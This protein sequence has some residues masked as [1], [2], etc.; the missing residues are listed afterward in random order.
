MHPEQ[1]SRIAYEGEQVIAFPKK[2]L[3]KC[4]RL[5]LIKHL[6]INRIGIFP[7]AANHYYSRE[8]GKATYCVFL[9]CY[10]GEG[11]I[12]IDKKN[13]TLKPGDAFFIPPYVAHSYGASATKPWSIFWMHIS[14]DNAVELYPIS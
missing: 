1:K 9:H 5:P 10:D 4:S 6:Y 13:Y 3:S 8:S 7:H 2:V 11:W 12:K 14:G